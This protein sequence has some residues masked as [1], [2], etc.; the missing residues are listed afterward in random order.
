MQLWDADS[1]GP[2]EPLINYSV[3][4]VDEASIVAGKLNIANTGGDLTMTLLL[5]RE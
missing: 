5:I 4:T 1:P 2:A 3:I